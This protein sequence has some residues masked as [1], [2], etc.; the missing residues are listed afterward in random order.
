M[1]VDFLGAGGGKVVRGFEGSFEVD[2][3]E[4]GAALSKRFLPKGCLFVGEEIEG[5]EADGDFL[6]V[7]KVG[8]AAISL[9]FA[10]S[11]LEVEEAEFFAFFKGD[12]FTV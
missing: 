9:L 1:G 8:L 11:F 12:D 3:V 10:E 6:W 2:G 4:L 5:D 7:E